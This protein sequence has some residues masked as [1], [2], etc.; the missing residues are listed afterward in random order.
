MRR[1][2]FASAAAA[3]LCAALWSPLP[4][5]TVISDARTTPVATST[6]NNGAA[7]DLR[8]AAGGSVRPPAGPAVTLD[9][10][11]DVTNEGTIEVLNSN[12][13]AGLLIGGGR[14]GAAINRGS[15]SVGEDFTPTDG[16]NDGDLDG[17][18]AQGS[19]RYGIRVTGPSAFVGTVT[20]DAAGR[21]TVEGSDSFGVSV[22][23][24][25]TGDLDL[26]GATSVVG[27]GA[28]AVSIT[29]P[30][31]GDVTVGAASATGAGAVGVEVAGPVGGGLTLSNQVAVTGY[32]STIR[33]SDVSRL[34][35]DDLLQGGP[36][37]RVAADV[38][39]GVLLDAPPPDLSS[40]DADEDDDGVPDASETA[41]NL[42]SFGGAPALAIGV[43]GR[44]LT[45]GAVEGG[46]SGLVI[47]GRAGGFGVY[48]GVAADA[49]RIGGE[50]GG[51]VTLAEGLRLTGTLD[52]VA[53]GA[54]ATA[55]R[56]GAGAA[57]PTLLLSGAANASSA[58]GAGAARTVLIEQGAT[59]AT[60]RNTGRL[61]AG[62]AGGA[63][64]AVAIEDRSGGLALVENAG[65]ISATRT[66]SATDGAVQGRTIALD[67]SANTSGVVVR[68]QAVSDG[69]DAPALAGDLL[70]GSGADLLE[71]LNGTARGGVAFG[72][73]ADRLALD[74]GAVLTGDVGDSDG[75]LAV[76]IRNGRLE[77]LNAA[78]LNLDTLDV[79]A[80]G[81]LVL[82]VG[83]QNTT[84][85]AL[86]VAGTAAFAEGADVGVRLS[87][88]IDEPRRFLLVQAGA[89]QAPGLENRALED[90]PFLFMSELGVDQAANRVFLDVRRRTA[91][92]AGLNRAEAGAFDGVYRALGQDAAVRDAVLAQTSQEGF[93]SVYRQL[94]P[95]HAGGALYA[96]ANGSRAMSTA[97]T[98]RAHAQ[99]RGDALGGWL[100][101]VGFRVERERGDDAGF[102]AGGFGLMGGADTPLLGGVVGV[103]AAFLAADV[104]D[105]A[106]TVT[107]SLNLTSLE[108]GLYYQAVFGR[109]TASARGA[110]GYASFESDRRL[111]I[112]GLSRAA[113]SDWSGLTAAGH[114]GTSYLV[115]LGA[116]HLRPEASLDAF[117]LREGEHA[118]SGGGGAFALAVDE[119]TSSLVS[120]SA[121]LN[122]GA[123]FGRSGLVAELTGGWRQ[124]LAGGA[125]DTTAR[126]G[127]AGA[128]FTLT[129]ADAPEG[130][131][132]LGLRLTH[133]SEWSFVSL[134][135]RAE[136]GEDYA[137]ADLRLNIRFLF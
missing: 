68:Q 41:A 124:T 88:L 100:Q 25:V 71:L 39:G 22:E 35:A 16:D 79:A 40:T 63:G 17:P 11:N 60:L 125:G 95:E 136:A 134:Q 107:E 118:E 15:I 45:I 43:A 128:P 42:Q 130:A 92:E 19:G 74:G 48:D 126:F 50:Q 10:D 85:A 59:V 105:E 36:A 8:I 44:D 58:G 72:A 38:A 12:G 26:L 65:I 51:T 96:L 2:L 91:A 67:L 132:V 99:S 104:D 81:G 21:I 70:L 69:E 62:V 20:Q 119:R 73:G 78:P 30:V 133:E 9:S 18:F 115:P 111:E 31:T 75:R 37:V 13:A 14:T 113:A 131:G 33:G 5:Q 4:A 24:G 97:L 34:D 108:G 66:A 46:G 129:P 89:L 82:T 80:D 98:E 27:D 94:L 23:S 86:Q 116:F 93:A 103:S 122:L 77:L 53:A 84:A 102:E 28:R 87:G 6:V 1:I 61:L 83:E 109:L 7:D 106:A 55:L 117:H 123:R 52:A 90:T 101:E 121:L 54:D 112:G 49:V 137:A 64:D 32:R 57:S 127:D 120:G 3:P 110:V 135:A 114:L 56:L 29:G 76:D 47:R